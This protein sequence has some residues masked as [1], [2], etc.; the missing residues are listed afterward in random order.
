MIYCISNNK[1]IELMYDQNKIEEKIFEITKK[2]ISDLKSEN[3]TMV[4]L[5]KGSFIFASDLLRSLFCEGLNP[6]VEFIKVSSYH[7]KMESSGILNI[8]SNIPQSIKGADVLL[9]DDICDT[10]LTLKE[11]KNLLIEKGANSVK[12]CV[13]LN[14]QEKR[15]VDINP[16]YV[17]FEIPDIFVVGYGL[18]YDE[19]YRGMHWLGKIN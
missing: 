4:V 15:L 7:G 2:I 14:K 18:D 9:V 3:L 10:G 5:L 6:T 16:D 1:I 8:E 12:T 17:C 19:K 13:L 11:M